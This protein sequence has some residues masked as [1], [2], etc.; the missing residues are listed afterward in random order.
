METD[1]EA[2]VSVAIERPGLYLVATPI[3]NLGDISLRALALLRTVDLILAEDTRTSLRLLDR[4]TIRKPLEALHQHNEVAR[5]EALVTRIQQDTLAVALVSD[6][7]TPLLCDPGFPLVRAALAAG[8]A[9]TALP[10]ASALLCALT[11]SGL[12]AERFVFEGFLPPKSAARRAALETLTR[13]P[14]T[15]VFHESAH[16][17]SAT[18]DDLLAVMGPMRQLAIARELTKLH[19]TVYRGSIAEVHARMAADPH[20]TRG[21]FVVVL[22][23]ADEAPDAELPSRLLAALRGR[24]S[25]RDAVEVVHEVTGYS[26]NQ[27]YRMSLGAES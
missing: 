9:V 5:A 12:P 19:E 10:G 1:K 4:Y 21:E 17:I 7:G 16:R 14:R 22:G 20:A 24:L 27:L 18:L 3:G 6:A 13:E 8:L 26:R 11:V 15:L 25:A 2:T 23:G